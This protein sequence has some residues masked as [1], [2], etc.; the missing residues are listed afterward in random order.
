MTVRINTR[1]EPTRR[2]L[3][4]LRADGYT[5]GEVERKTG[6]VSRDLFGAFDIVGFRYPRESI[7]V[8]TTSD[9]HFADRVKKVGRCQELP[10]LILAGVVIEVHGWKEGREEPRVTRFQ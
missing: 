6:P 2:S 3:D 7:L 9:S 1:G 5:A 4:R 8:Q 10:A